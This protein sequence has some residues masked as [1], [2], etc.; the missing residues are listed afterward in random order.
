MTGMADSQVNISQ[1]NMKRFLI[2]FPPL[3]EQQHIV[4]KLD[5]LMA[6]CDE[7]E[8]S[9]K[10]SQRQNE[11]LLQQVLREALEPATVS[12]ATLS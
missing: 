8:A 5:E 1:D 3:S 12:D 11:L 10:E 6:Y 2:P 4:V 7:L 9:I